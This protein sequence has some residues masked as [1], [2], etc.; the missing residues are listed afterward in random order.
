MMNPRWK[1]R[2]RGLAAVLCLVAP[3]SACDEDIEYDYSA[4]AQVNRVNAIRINIGNQ[5]MTVFKDGRVTLGPLVLIRPSADVTTTLLDENDQVIAG[6]D[7][8]DIRVDMGRLTGGST[9]GVTFT[10]TSDFSGRFTATTAGTTNFTISLF[11]KVNR[12][13]AFGPYTMAMIVR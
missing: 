10:R 13:P 12:R 7:A 8:K 9:L 6:A 4:S 3:L 11:D 1:Q 2:A 5:E